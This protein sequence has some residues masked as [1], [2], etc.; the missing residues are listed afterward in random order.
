MYM[1]YWGLLIIIITRVQHIITQ[2]EHIVVAIKI[3]LHYYHDYSAVDQRIYCISNASTP[4]PPASVH[5][6]F[7]FALT[8]AKQNFWGVP[9]HPPCVLRHAYSHLTT[10]C[11]PD[12]YG[13]GGAPLGGNVR[14][15][16]LQQ[17]SPEMLIYRLSER[18]Y[19]KQKDKASQ[20]SIPIQI[21][22]T[23]FFT[24]TSQCCFS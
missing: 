17:T 22:S 18:G 24:C 13:P 21:V 4:A 20:L 11:K 5:I 2:F 15:K 16:K 23:P 3:K 1:F 14:S 8:F 10:P 6:W 7:H 9:P 19:F 12:G